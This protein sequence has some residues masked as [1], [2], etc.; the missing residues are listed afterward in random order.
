MP[1][2]RVASSTF[3]LGAWGCGAF[4]YDASIVAQLF[5]EALERDYRGVF[6]RVVFAVLD[7]TPETRFIG[8]FRERFVEASG[9]TDA[10]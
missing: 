10:R 3:I 8:P 2:P 1:H 9:H 5:G 7:S 6:E 4:G